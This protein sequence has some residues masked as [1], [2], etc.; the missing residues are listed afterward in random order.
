MSIHVIS[1]KYLP[2][3]IPIFPTMTL[4]LLLDRLQ[5]PGWVL[6]AA[7]TVWGIIALTLTI[8]TFAEKHEHPLDIPRQP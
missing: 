1:R 5:P 7:W 8:H 4:W 2:S 6:G 3:G